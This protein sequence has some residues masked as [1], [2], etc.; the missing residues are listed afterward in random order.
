MGTRPY[1]FNTGFDT[2]TAPSVTDP[3]AST[4]IVSLGYASKTY[5]KGVETIAALKAIGSTSRTDLQPVYVE[6]LDAWFHFDAG[7]SATGDDFNVIAPTAGTGRWLRVAAKGEGAGQDVATATNI[8]ALDN[9]TPVVRLTGSTTT[10]LRGILAGGSNQRLV[11]LNASSADVTI[12]HESGAVGTA[13]RR[14]SVNNSADVTLKPNGGALFA[15]DK[16]T[17]RWR[18]VSFTATGGTSWSDIDA[19]TAET[20]PDKA[21]L[22]YLGDASASTLDKITLE[23]L[24]KVINTFTAETSIDQASD[25]LAVYDATATAIR[26][27]TVN[28][29]LGGGTAYAL[30]YL[31][32]G[33]QNIANTTWSQVNIDTF[34]YNQNITVNPSSTYRLRPDVGGLYLILGRLWKFDS[35]DTAQLGIELRR[36][37]AVVAQEFAWEAQGGT[38]DTTISAWALYEFNGSTDYVELWA[39]QDT[40]ITRTLASSI[41]ETAIAMLRIR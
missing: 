12:V 16:T 24:W 5:A 35:T 10:N 36:N 38:K 11:L 29:L 3:S 14:I 39:Y 37:G 40:G 7:S 4:D 17:E 15:Y 2:V 23:N 6:E 33:F 28:S 41:P 25:F 19:K 34:L 13:A 1:D 22:L 26:K 21:D 20:A 30:A 18:L 27:A 32:A 31:S 8:D 9:T